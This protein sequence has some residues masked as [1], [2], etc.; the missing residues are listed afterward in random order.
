MRKLMSWYMSRKHTVLFQLFIVSKRK[1]N[2]WIYDVSFAYLCRFSLF[3][4]WHLLS[5]TLHKSLHNYPAWGRHLIIWSSVANDG[6]PDVWESL[7]PSFPLPKLDIHLW[8]VLN[9]TVSSS[10]PLLIEDIM[11]ANSFPI[12]RER[13]LIY[14][15]VLLNFISLT[16]HFKVT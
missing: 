10:S 12:S 4:H 2:S 14:E 6:R 13:I 16:A 15:A 9:E 3:Q 5:Q 8:H 11:E 1:R 7:M